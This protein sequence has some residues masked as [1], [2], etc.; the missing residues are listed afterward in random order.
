M[1]KILKVDSQKGL[2]KA[3]IQYK[4][5]LVAMVI[6]TRSCQAITNPYNHTTPGSILDGDTCIV[7]FFTTWS[8]NINLQLDNFENW[9]QNKLKRKKGLHLLSLV[10]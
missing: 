9:N 6:L 3:L 4:R 5:P 7:K 2:S 10:R 8:T 1:N